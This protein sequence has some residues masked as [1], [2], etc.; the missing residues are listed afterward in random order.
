M[1]SDDKL[2][3]ICICRRDVAA[4]MSIY[5]DT[6]NALRLDYGMNSHSASAVH[7]KDKSNWSDDTGVL[8]PLSSA[9]RLFNRTSEKSKQDSPRWESEICKIFLKQ[10][11]PDEH[12]VTQWDGS[13]L[14]QQ[15]HEQND[16]AT[17]QPTLNRL[18]KKQSKSKPAEA[19][20][21]D[22]VQQ[23]TLHY[24]ISLGPANTEL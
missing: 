24:S 7:T 15:A 21:F 1:L 5:V 10:G 19:A 4:C 17:C 20:A 18:L 12:P 6:H 23:A 11:E 16:I 3:T 14:N 13:G 9:V 8:E 22:G 2:T